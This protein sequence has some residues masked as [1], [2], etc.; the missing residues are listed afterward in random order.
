M[1]PNMV[2]VVDEEVDQSVDNDHDG[3]QETDTHVQ[4]H[5]PII[6]L[7]TGRRGSKGGKERKRNG[8]RD[9]RGRGRKERE[10]D[11]GRDRREGEGGRGRGMEGEIGEEG[12]G[13]RE[14]GERDGQTNK[15]Y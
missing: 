10:R 12:E 4:Q 15:H 6:D 5:G 13:V 14:K 9:R 7:E 8:R 2:S 1:D 3:C 11:G